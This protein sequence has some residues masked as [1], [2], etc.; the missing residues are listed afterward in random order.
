[1]RIS[2]VYKVY[3][4]DGMDSILYWCVEV[5]LI[6]SQ[7]TTLVCTQISYWMLFLKVYI[8]I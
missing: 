6:A 3:T 1:M 8:K 7:T 5:R 2:F 4:K